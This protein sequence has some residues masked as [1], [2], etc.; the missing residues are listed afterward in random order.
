ML[1][2]IVLELSIWVKSYWTS[3]LVK[4]DATCLNMSCSVRADTYFESLA[5]IFNLSYDF[6][7]LIW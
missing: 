1:A 5:D 2:N 7:R 3:F 6:D 4:E